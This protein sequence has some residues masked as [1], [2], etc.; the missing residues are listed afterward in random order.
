MPE[1]SFLRK[2]ESR[3]CLLTNEGKS[4]EPGFPITNVGNDRRGHWYE[5]GSQASIFVSW[6]SARKD[7]IWWRAG[8]LNPR[9]QR[10]ERCALPTELAPHVLHS[11]KRA[12]ALQS[13]Q[14]SRIW[15]VRPVTLNRPSANNRMALGNRPCSTFRMRSD[16]L[17]SVSP[18]STG[19]ACCRIIGPVSIPSVTK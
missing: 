2:Q 13:N 7:E 10:C 6:G 18:S 15:T 3:V 5:K 17:S 9:P 11:T 14:A 8:D 4:K 19:T 12:G 1:P 16:K